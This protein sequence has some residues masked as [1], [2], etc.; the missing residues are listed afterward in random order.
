MKARRSIHVA[1]ITLLAMSFTACNFIQTEKTGDSIDELPLDSVKAITKEAYIYAYPM[2]DAYRIE[3]AYFIDTTNPEFKAPLNQLRN[4]AHVYTP[5]DKAVQTPN[6]DTPYSMAGLD[7]RNEPMVL[8][9]PEIE[10]DR[11]FSFQLIDLYT[12][13]FDYIGSR[14]TGNDGGVYMIAGPGWKG[15]KPEGITKV[16]RSETEFVLVIGRTQLFD[17]AD[18]DNVKK[19]QDAYKLEPLSSFLHTTPP[20]ETSEVYH[21]TQL[22]EDLQHLSYDKTRIIPPLTSVLEKKSIETFN[23][24]NFLLQFCPTHPSEEGLMT[25]F[26]KI[27]IGAGQTIDTTL[28]SP[29][30]IAAMKEGIHEAWTQDFARLKQQIDEGKVTSGDVFGTREYLKNNYTYRMGAAVLG[31][32][33]NS[34][35]EAMYPLYTIDA[36]GQPLDGSKHNYTLHF[37]ADESPPVNAFWSLTM[38][39]LPSSLL[40]DNPINRYLL[41][42]PMLPDFKRDKDGGITFYIQKTS[43]GKD[44]EA[45]W[46]PAPDGLFMVVLRLYWPKESALDGSWKNPPLEAVK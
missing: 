35:H 30:V 3:Y 7:L 24:L 16:F 6:S 20:P 18:L 37:N 9:V 22:T 2:A 11:Y 10:K 39:E 21:H 14:T 8:T 19:I 40:V 45:N 46:L 44:K 28:L 25:R 31:I 12:F 1:F 41:N 32:F 26:A 33:G 36:E 43:P 27:G 15:E 34:K 23:I 38:Y 17:K 42:S 29:E 5:D 13:N 4:I